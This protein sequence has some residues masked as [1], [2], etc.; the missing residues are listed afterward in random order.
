MRAVSLLAPMHSTRP[1]GVSDP[2]F[3]NRLVWEVLCDICAS[4]TWPYVRF[5]LA[6]EPGLE[7]H[8]GTLQFQSLIA[9]LAR[10]AAARAVSGRV[11]V[12]CVHQAGRLR[13]AVVDEGI[14]A[15]SAAQPAAL[16]AIAEELGVQGDAVEIATRAGEGSTIQVP[17][18]DLRRS[19][20]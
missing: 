2:P 6:C 10:H 15:D 7:V 16:R 13:I 17:W 8:H 1:A 9:A 5:E 20:F 19:A 14:R 4:K 12:T 11:L 3:A 18:P